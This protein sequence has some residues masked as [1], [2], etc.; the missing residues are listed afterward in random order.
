MQGTTTQNS[1]YKLKFPQNLTRITG[2]SD[3]YL[4]T[5]MIISRSIRLGMR[6]V[7]ANNIREHKYT[8]FLL[9]NFFFSKIVP[10]MK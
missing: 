1:Q 7:S 2:T 9:N 5:F 4:H 10:F 8:H 6:N 3:K